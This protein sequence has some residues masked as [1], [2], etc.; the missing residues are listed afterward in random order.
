QKPS[1]RRSRRKTAILTALLPTLSAATYA[2]AAEIRATAVIAVARDPSGQKAAAATAALL[3]TRVQATDDLRLVDPIRVLSGD[4]GTRKEELLERAREALEAGR[5]EYDALALDTAIARLGQAVS[6]FQRTGPLLGDMNELATAYA[7]L[8]AALI[9]RGSADEGESTFVELLT[10]SP[11]YQLTDFP[12]PVLRIFERAVRRVDRAAA[13]NV[14]IY[15]TPPYA[16]VFVDGRFEGVTPLELRGVL[17]GTHYIRL[18]KLGYRVHGA[19]MEVAPRQ[20]VTSQTR[21]RS[22]DRGAELRDLAARGAREVDPDGM[23][24]ALR[25]LARTLN[26]DRVIFVAVSQSGRD[27]SLT[28]GVFDGPGSKRIATQ[29]AVVAVDRETYRRDLGRYLDQ[30]IGAARGQQTAGTAAAQG[31]PG[32]EP[33]APQVEPPPPSSSALN[34]DLPPPA[35]AN[36]A[37]GAP[38]R[39]R[40]RTPVGTYVGWSLVGTGA[41]SL[42]AGTAFG[43][44]ALSDHGSFNDTPQNSPDLKDTQ[45]SGK[46]NA[47]LADVFYG[48]GGALVLGGVTTLLFV[49][50]S[51]S[52]SSDVFQVE[53]AGL[54]PT[55]GGAVLSLGGSF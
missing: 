54:T 31:L 30:L 45:D 4:P 3:R 6:L 21:L 38:A 51:E 19:P 7:Y 35:D 44:L 2:H 13:G 34:Q 49:E 18:E 46:R 17:A 53:Q 9:L 24:G 36:P 16:A 43:V 41:A 25:A 12:P 50:F 26:A 42:I 32:R 39:Q 11:N 15:S 27:A 5:R 14:E 48:V 8:A 29:R 40:R 28:G 20:S 22:A 55:D 23:G 37:M 52:T 1:L 47:L 33:S 10:I